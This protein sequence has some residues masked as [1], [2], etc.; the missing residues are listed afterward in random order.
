MDLRKLISLII[1]VILVA[2]IALF[3]AFR[4]SELIFWGIIIVGFAVA[5]IIRRKKE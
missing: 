5:L 1:I 4:Y 2:N 3:A